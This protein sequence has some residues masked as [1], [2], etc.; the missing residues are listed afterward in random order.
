MSL[1]FSIH[2]PRHPR[3]RPQGAQEAGAGWGEMQGSLRVQSGFVL[4]C[5]FLING[6]TKRPVR[7]YLFFF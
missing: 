6:P 4:S 1:H 2:A 7:G 3:Q 5:F